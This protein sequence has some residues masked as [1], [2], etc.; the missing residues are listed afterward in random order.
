MSFV[1]FQGVSYKSFILTDYNPYLILVDH[2]V[3]RNNMKYNQIE[4]HK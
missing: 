3:Y 2:I 4:F 1:R